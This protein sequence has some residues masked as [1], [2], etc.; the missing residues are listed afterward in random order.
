[1][2][3]ENPDTVEKLV[4][5]QLKVKDVLADAFL[6]R[7]SK[8]STDLSTLSPQLQLLINMELEQKQM[9]QDIANVNQRVDGIRDIVRLNTVNWRK[10]TSNM[11]SKIA[12]AWGSHDH[13]RDVRNKAYEELNRR[14]KV[15][16][17]VR[18]KNKRQRMAEE[19]ANKSKRD[20]VSLVDIIADDPKLIE[21]YVAIIK[22]LAIEA[23]IADV[24]IIE[25][26]K[27]RMIKMILDRPNIKNVVNNIKRDLTSL[28]WLSNDN[29]QV[30]HMMRE[31]GEMCVMTSEDLLESIETA[32]KSISERMDCLSE[33]VQEMAKSLPEETYL[34]RL[35][36]PYE[37]VSW[38]KSGA[39]EGM[40]LGALIGFPCPVV[41]YDLSD[42]EF[43][44]LECWN[45]PISEINDNYEE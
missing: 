38:D 8:T 27:R 20:K 15:N 23:G 33:A 1:M 6:K 7:E 29:G 14:F 43:S 30:K 24:D 35:N 11:I 12:M 10:E 36:A 4:N 22:E 18:Q 28:H 39:P 40:C 21:G 31:D 2:K 42:S 5:Y 37:K 44:C 41:E 32:V 26:K 34:Q 13:I 25:E 9:Q 3:E 19:G 16:L 17:E 45:T